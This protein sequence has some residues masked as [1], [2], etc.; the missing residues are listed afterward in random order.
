MSTLTFQQYVGGPD[1]VK[2]ESAF[3]SSQR[4]MIYNFG[5][6]VAGWTITSDYQTLVVDSIGYNRITGEPNFANS[7]VIGSFPK[8]EVTGD[9]AP[10]I[11][12]TVAGNV[13]VTIPANMYT[14]PVIP[15]ARTNV[16]ITVFSVTW[17]DT[18][19][20]PQIN[21][22]RWALLQSWEPDVE[23]ADPTT[24]IG[25]TPLAGS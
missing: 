14:G 2:I 22:H 10:T 11:I 9:A 19:T 15:D 24:G 12:D 25:Y 8:V 7:A 13:A 1:S 17:E 6:N 20:P 4:T 3:P 18:T 16:A 21:S 23:I 5:K